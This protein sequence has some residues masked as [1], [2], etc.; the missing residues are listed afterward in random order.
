ML[1]NMLPLLAALVCCASAPLEAQQAPAQNSPSTIKPPPL[2]SAPIRLDPRRDELRAAIEAA[3]RGTLST[4]QSEAIATH[5]AAAWVE[6]AALKR[7]IDTLPA[8]RGQAFLAKYKGQ[9]V[10]GAFREIWLASLSRKQDWPTFRLAWSNDIDDLGLRCAELDARQ[11]TGNADA[12]WVRDAQAAWSGTA[13]AFPETCDAPFAILASKGGLTSA[14]RW[15]RIDKVA[16]NWDSASMRAAAR[17]LP[18][19]EKALAEDYASFFD[20][21]NDRALGWPKTARSRMMAS[22]GLARLAKSLPMSVDTQ[23]PKYAQAFDFT[24]ADRGRV[25][26]QAAL[27]TVASYEPDS[28]K[29]LADVPASAYDERLH[30]WRVREAMSRSD[31]PAALSAIEKMGDKQRS[32]SRWTYF[33]ARLKEMTGDKAGAQALYRQAARKP[34]FHGFLAADRIDQPYALCPVDPQ[35]GGAAQAQ[36]ARDP[37]IVR[38]MALYQVDR[39]G[40]AQREWDDALSRFDDM[41]RRNAVAVAQENGWFDR[42]V[43]ALGKQPEEQRMYALRFPIHHDA[44]IRREAAKNGLDPAWVAAEIRAESVFNPNARS[45]ANAMGLMQIVPTTGLATARRIG[46]P[47]NGVQTLYDPDANIAIGAAYLRELYDKYGPPYMVLAGYNAGPAPLARW[48]AQRPGM[49]PDFWIETLSYKETREYVARVLA[50][51]VIY[52]WRLNGDAAPISQRMLGKTAARKSFECPGPLAA[53]S[54]SEAQ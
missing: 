53:A 7:D 47:W 52:D 27:W 24:E 46:V 54:K 37:A 15:E 12:Q 8:S 19:E 42:A 40:W 39:P 16:A 29:R 41:Q 11:A 5:P 48:Q 17:G 13:K 10:A 35:V 43:F 33:E 3:D 38:A 49:D 4:A 21:V 25:L 45:G 36:V 51:S 50:F 28:A 30:E 9:A 18:S 6:Y 23:L 31:W 2:T 44:T 34:E 22:Q 1:R 20:A 26:Y 14:M 32:D